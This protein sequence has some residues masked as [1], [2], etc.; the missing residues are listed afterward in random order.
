MQI[1]PTNCVNNEIRPEKLMSD[2]SPNT[3]NLA[4][5]CRIVTKLEQL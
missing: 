4:D 2:F 1:T 3:N 5:F